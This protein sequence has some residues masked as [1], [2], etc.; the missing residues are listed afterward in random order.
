MR[1]DSEKS[2]FDVEMLQ[3]S[4]STGT[5]VI[6]FTREASLDILQSQDSN[7]FLTVAVRNKS[8]LTKF[9]N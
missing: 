9:N 4:Y 8:N 3:E 6:S 1:L 5:T 2:H 7:H